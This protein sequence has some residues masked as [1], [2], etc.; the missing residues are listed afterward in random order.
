MEAFK[1]SAVYGKGSAIGKSAQENPN[2]R[3]IPDGLV[4]SSNEVD[5]FIEDIPVKAL[6][7]TGATVSIVSETFYRQHLSHVVMEPLEDILDI[8]SATGDN[9]P[10]H[11]YIE[12][13]L[14]TH[15]SGNGSVNG[16]FLVAPDTRYNVSVPV[17]LGTNIL[18]E[19]LDGCKTTYG[20]RFLQHADL[21]TPYYLAYRCMVLQE[22]TVRQN[23]WRLGL[24][25]SVET[26]NVI[27]KPN[28]CVTIK[29]QL[30]KGVSYPQVT[31]LLQ[32]T[33][34]SSIP[35]DL[36]IAPTIV[37]YHQHNM[38]TIDVNV[39]NLTTLTVVVP[40][41]SILCELCLS[42]CSNLTLLNL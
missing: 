3:T 38:G 32:P 10:Y 30:V 19:L 33:A 17:L 2:K 34:T 4:G 42:P 8:E 39:S 22:K 5:I 21:H 11:G 40:T 41:R 1:L 9:L 25:K 6:L 37:D 20:V 23:D 14:Y 18:K 15:G 27:I 28:T 13:V 7:D 36:D 35:S 26:R 12:V 16:L 31:A 29:G 24:V